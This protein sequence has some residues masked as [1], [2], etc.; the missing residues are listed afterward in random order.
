MGEQLV[1]SP[2]VWP[3]LCT[4]L[5]SSLPSPRALFTACPSHTLYPPAHMH[6]YTPACPRY[7]VPMLAMKF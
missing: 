1:P 4:L 2:F 5:L 7:P 6:C 3:V